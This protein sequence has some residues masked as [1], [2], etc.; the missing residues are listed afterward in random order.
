MGGIDLWRANGLAQAA[1]ELDLNQEADVVALR[2]I[3]LKI[4]RRLPA[5]RAADLTDRR[6]ARHAAHQRAR[7][8]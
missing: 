1:A 7:P 3:A 6:R 8:V 2:R 5:E 4:T